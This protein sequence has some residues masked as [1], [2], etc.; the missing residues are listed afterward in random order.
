[1]ASEWDSFEPEDTNDWASYQPESIVVEKKEQQPVGGLDLVK[2]AYQS[3]M[4]V[5][6]DTGLSIADAERSLAAGAIK[7]PTEVLGAGLQVGEDIGGNIRGAINLATDQ[8]QGAID[9]TLS[10]YIKGKGRQA[11]EIIRPEDQGV[12]GRV[13]EE[14]GSYALPSAGVTKM[15]INTGSLLANVPRTLGMFENMLVQAAKDPKVAMALDQTISSIM[16]TSGQLSEEA[17]L[18][19]MQRALVELGVGITSGAAIPGAIMK[20]KNLLTKT[21][22]GLSVLSK[23]ASGKYLNDVAAEDPDFWRTFNKNLKASKKYGVEMDLPELTINPELK[24]AKKSLIEEFQGGAT[25]E[26]KTLER[27][28]EQVRQSFDF[29]PALTDDAIRSID[30]SIEATEKSLQKNIDSA[31][32]LA[33]REAVPFSQSS[34]KDAGEAALIRLDEAESLVNQ[35]I[36]ILYEKVGLDVPIET[37]IVRNAINSAKRSA[38]PGNQWRGELSPHL[39]KITNTLVNE[40]DLI[41]SLPLEGIHELQGLLKTEIRTSRAEGNKQLVKELS[42]VLGATYKQM[43]NVRGLTQ[44]NVSLL[45]SANEQSRIAHSRFDESRVSILNRVDTQGVVKTAPEDVIKNIIKPD[46]QKNSFRAVTAYQDAIGDQKKAKDIL[47]QGFIAKLA[48]LSLSK[49]TL[50][51]PDQL[52]NVKATENFLRQHKNFLQAAGLQSEFKDVASASRVMDSAQETLKSTVDQMARSELALWSKSD[53]PVK[54]ISKAIKSGRIKKIIADAKNKPLILR[55]IN[56]ATWEGVLKDANISRGMQGFESDMTV[57][58][59]RNLM[60]RSAKNL[61]MGLGP[62]HYKHARD[63]MRIVDSI[64]VD[65][66]KTAGFVTEKPM[67][68][69]AEKLL[70]GLRAAAHGFVRPDLIVV[71]AGKRSLE[72]KLLKESK[73]LVIDAMVN[74]G[75]A[76]DLMRTYRG[77]TT[78]KKLVEATLAPFAASGLNDKK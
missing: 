67:S 9:H 53:D 71:Q 46:T 20:G 42:K 8:P 15:M 27:Q 33:V 66:T 11:A 47:R 28:A 72:A 10:E 16:A 44:E 17:G 25:R 78:G 77:S 48:S 60:Q 13:L 2:N 45:K 29:D 74:P 7:M 18:S 50:K 22:E 69:L 5:L 34:L 76:K 30:R 26:L 73:K 12:G 19:P 31:E 52:L 43:D 39:K 55:G 4:T 6:K 37:D 38:L 41:E 65:T 57:E 70:T 1:M 68:D 32:R 36:N 64:M 21:K 24:A 56:E 49:P 40:D 14:V 23:Q 63:L 75:L 59:L 51:S 62:I 54:Y 3:L 58:S 61:E 35:R